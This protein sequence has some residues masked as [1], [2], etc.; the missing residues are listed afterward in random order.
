MK[1]L[2]YK[3]ANSADDVTLREAELKDL[4]DL[5]QIY[6]YFVEKTAITFDLY[7]FS[8]K[9][10]EEWFHYYNKNERHRLFVAEMNDTIIGYASSSPFRPKD[11]FL[12][13]VET[14]IY[15]I[16]VAQGM[17]IGS[18][19]YR[20]LFDALEGVDVHKAYAGITIPNDQSIALH[21]SFGFNK[22]GLFKEVGR[23]FDRYH[24]VEW[25][26]K[27]LNSGE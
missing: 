11:A 14:S 9:A 6:N 10:R 5:T 24:D 12:I 22:V 26:E 4:T 15:L 1:P 8:V 2:S 3:P 27:P 20:Y 23:K 19:L 13:S 18:V 21:R 17:Q 7:P 25:W 16:S